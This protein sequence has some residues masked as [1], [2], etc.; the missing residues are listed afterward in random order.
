MRGL[1]SSTSDDA[2]RLAF[3][4]KLMYPYMQAALDILKAS[5]GKPD[6]I[7]E[8]IRREALERL[9][10]QYTTAVDEYSQPSSTRSALLTSAPA[11]AADADADS[12]TSPR[13]SQR[14]G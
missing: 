9:Q 4:R 6:A 2:D 7:R 3:K 13:S 14:S 5:A 8:P 11:P 12:A 1:V 10:T